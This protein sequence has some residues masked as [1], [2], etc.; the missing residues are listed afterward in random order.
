VSNPNPPQYPQQPQQPAYAQPQQ[1]AYAQPGAPAA[2]VHAPRPALPT[3]L[4]Q[5][6]AFALV[7]II[8]AFVQP[9][10][11]VVFGHIALSQIK[12]NGDAGRGMALTGL[13][14]GYVYVAF[15]VLFVIAYVGFIITMVASIGTWSSGSYSRL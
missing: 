14:I 1:P 9:I 15:I 4:A 5:T 13:I 2:P 3:A 8:L 7:S 11:A 6:N 10:A 12:R